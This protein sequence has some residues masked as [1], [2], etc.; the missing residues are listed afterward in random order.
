MLIFGTDLE[1]VQM[2]NDK[3]TLIWKFWYERSGR[4][5]VILGIKILRN[6]NKLMLSQSHYIEKIL[7]RF[8]KLTVYMSAL[9]SKYVL[10]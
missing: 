3:E 7:K 8:N 4:S 6:N 2:T 9:R 10:D 5:Y 1:Q